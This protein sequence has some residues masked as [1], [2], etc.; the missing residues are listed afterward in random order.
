MNGCDAINYFFLSIIWYVIRF[1]WNHT[2]GVGFMQI[3]LGYLKKF[4]CN[5]VETCYVIMD[6]KIK[7]LKSK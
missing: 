3:F 4:D 1:T 6:I 5:T 2:Q 7:E